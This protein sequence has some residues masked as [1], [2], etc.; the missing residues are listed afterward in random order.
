M[1]LLFCNKSA[2]WC[3]PAC[4]STVASA[5]LQ[6]PRTT[7]TR[8][9]FCT[10]IA[11]GPVAP[12]QRVPQPPQVVR[13]VGK[14]DA[15][16]TTQL[17]PTPQAGCK[18]RLHGADLLAVANP[19]ATTESLLHPSRLAATT[20]ATDCASTACCHFLARF[21]HCHRGLPPTPSLPPGCRSAAHQHMHRGS[22][23]GSECAP[24]AATR[25]S[26]RS[27][28][29]PGLMYGSPSSQAQ[30]RSSR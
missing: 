25:G 27:N 6:D 3:S 28:R 12:L 26:A 20:V 11:V 24:P 4:H 30:R 19:L 29:F 23:L 8:R 14:G 2:H 15:L 1:A 17:R 16:P 18:R 10:P 9:G 22:G 13:I 5:A 21:R 7:F